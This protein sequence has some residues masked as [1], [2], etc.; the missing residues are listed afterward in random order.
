MQGL[1][2]NNDLFRLDIEKYNFLR[3]V[4]PF[5]FFPKSRKGAKS[6][7]S[8]AMLKPVSLYVKKP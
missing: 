8:L 1:G 7:A 3:Q 5:D 4:G 6:L 2:E